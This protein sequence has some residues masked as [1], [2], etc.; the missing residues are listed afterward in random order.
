MHHQSGVVLASGKSWKTFRQFSL[1]T[2]RD[3][4][5][6]K[7]SIEK[8]IQ[9]ETQRLVEELWKSQGKHWSGQGME[10][11]TEVGEMGTQREER[12]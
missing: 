4:G 11:L 6:G 10:A 7:Q 12:T 3:F 1:T 2:M 8:L 5:M 9:N